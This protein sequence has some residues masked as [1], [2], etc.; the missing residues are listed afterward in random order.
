[1]ANGVE[2]LFSKSKALNSI[3]NPNTTPPKKKSILLVRNKT[4]KEARV[5]GNRSDSKSR[6]IQVKWKLLLKMHTNFRA[7]DGQAYQ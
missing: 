7:L 6:L 3:P 5:T 1:V 2:H 4:K